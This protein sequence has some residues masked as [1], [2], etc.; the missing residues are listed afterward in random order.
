MRLVGGCEVAVAMSPLRLWNLRDL[1]ATG[2]GS[3]PEEGRGSLIEEYVDECVCVVD[4]RVFYSAVQ[5]TVEWI[6]SAAVKAARHRS[7]G[8]VKVDEIKMLQT[9]HRHKD[10]KAECR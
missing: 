1:F 3:T 10:T 8:G 6:R 2:A 5:S 7:I 9:T 4:S